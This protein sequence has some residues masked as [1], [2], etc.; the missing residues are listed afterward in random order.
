M[1]CR[2]FTTVHRHGCAYGGVARSDSC[3]HGGW[4]PAPNEGTLSKVIP[5]ANASPMSRARAAMGDCVTCLP[6]QYVTV[7]HQINY[8]VFLLLFVF[9][10]VIFCTKIKSFWRQSVDEP[11]HRRHGAVHVIAWSKAASVKTIA[12]RAVRD[13]HLQ[14]CE[15]RVETSWKGDSRSRKQMRE[16][17]NNRKVSLR[18]TLPRSVTHY[19]P[20]L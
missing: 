19:V 8:F 4:R 9:V 13:H 7:H 11:V 1:S 10:I 14:F 2:A 17:E 16:E 20:L 5:S 18:R 15:S 6:V 3:L 12:A